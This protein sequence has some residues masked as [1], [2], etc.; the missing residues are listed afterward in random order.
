MTGRP[1]CA[2]PRSPLPSRNFRL[3]RKVLCAWAGRTVEFAMEN[4]HDDEHERHFFDLCRVLSP[5]AAGTMRR[6]LSESPEL[7]VS[8]KTV[9][10]ALLCCVHA[11]ALV[12]LSLLVRETGA[13]L[14]E[15]AKAR[16]VH[17]VC[18]AERALP[19]YTF[20]VEQQGWPVHVLD[21]DGNSCFHMACR[22]GK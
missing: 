17:A 20:L 3:T 22:A 15:D 18:V 4:I 9:E 7:L 14:D 16:M 6:L 19:M 1:N 8:L 11:G 12:Q 10:R 13:R 21:D 2:L 5:A